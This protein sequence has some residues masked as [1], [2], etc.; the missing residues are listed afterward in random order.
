MEEKDWKDTDGYSGEQRNWACVAGTLLCSVF[1][2]CGVV[3]SSDAVAVAGVVCLMLCCAA[4]MV[5]D[6]LVSATWVKA[7]ENPVRTEVV[8]SVQATSDDILTVAA[9]LAPSKETD[10]LED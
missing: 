5:T 8:K 1:A 3:F 9:V 6:S 7:H 10:I 4:F 2:L